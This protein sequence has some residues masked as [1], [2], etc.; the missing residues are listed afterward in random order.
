MPMSSFMEGRLE[1]KIRQ[2]NLIFIII[3][4]VFC[5]ATTFISCTQE[6]GTE[7]PFVEIQNIENKSDARLINAF[8]S[9]IPHVVR[10]KGTPG[11]NIALARRG[12][13][14]WEAGFGWVSLFLLN[15]CSATLS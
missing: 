6:T 11:L 4:T 9:Y 10:D 5:L 8:R 14:I 12:K 3:L 15:F 1:N 2:R 7:V 13:I